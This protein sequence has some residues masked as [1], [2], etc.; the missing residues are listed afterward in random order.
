MGPEGTPAASLLREF[1]TVQ[2]VRVAE[3]LR[4]AKGFGQ[5]VA[6]GQEA[7]YRSQNAH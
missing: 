1:R 4:L 5:Y 3:F 6:T 2:E 7:P